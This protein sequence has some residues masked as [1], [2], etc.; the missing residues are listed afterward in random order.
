MPAIIKTSIIVG[1][2]MGFLTV[3]FPEYWLTFLIIF[4]ATVALE[5]IVETIGR[6]WFK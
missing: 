6:T 4:S 2:I 3:M 5:V 1:I